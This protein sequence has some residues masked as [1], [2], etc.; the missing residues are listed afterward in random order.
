MLDPVFFVQQQ[1]PWHACKTVTNVSIYR[2][3]DLNVLRRQLAA[4]H[5]VV[6]FWERLTL[7]PLVEHVLNA[8]LIPPLHTHICGREIASLAQRA[9]TMRWCVITLYI[10]YGQ[11]T[12]R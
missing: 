9:W 11:H 6:G 1:R 3:R 5:D 2:P 10:G 7:E 8:L 4:P 12:K